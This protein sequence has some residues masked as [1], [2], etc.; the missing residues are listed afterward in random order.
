MLND[1]DYAQKVEKKRKWY[2]ENGFQNNLIE[3]P[4]DGMS[5]KDSIKYIFEKILNIW[6]TTI[7]QALS[8]KFGVS[9]TP[10]VMMVLAMT[11]IWRMSSPSC[12]HLAKAPI[13]STITKTLAKN[14]QCQLIGE[15][16]NSTSIH[17][18]YICKFRNAAPPTKIC[19]R[20]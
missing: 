9:A 11:T 20:V 3:T 4:I 13:A 5:L 10:F 7:H 6:A 2:S 18:T 12:K 16:Q 14:L 17:I 1:F 15:F 19:K 8:V